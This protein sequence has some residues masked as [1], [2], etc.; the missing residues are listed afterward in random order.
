MA[1]KQDGRA[2]SSTFLKGQETA[3]LPC[4][5]GENVPNAGAAE[6]KSLFLDCY[7]ISLT[8]GAYNIASLPDQVELA[9]VMIVS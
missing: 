5:L 3:S 4:L 9:D 1:P 8:D 7:Q 6:E 2:G